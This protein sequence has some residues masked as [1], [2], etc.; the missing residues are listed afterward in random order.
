MRVLSNNPDKIRAL[1]EA[2]LNVIERVPIEIAAQEPAAHYLRTKKE[3][4]GHLID[5][6]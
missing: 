1:E 2:G 3:K 5:L 4:L 6:P